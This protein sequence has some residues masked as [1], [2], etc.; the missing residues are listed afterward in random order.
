[1]R[2]V[3][4]PDRGAVIVETALALPIMFV[5]ILGLFDLGMWSMNANQAANAARDGARAGILTHE[6]AD[7]PSSADRDAI[8]AAALARLP[9]GT[10]RPDDVSISCVDQ[11][12]TTVPCHTA[13][14]DEDR[15][16]VEVRWVWPLVTPVAGMIGTTDGVARGVATMEIVGRPDPGPPDDGGT[17]P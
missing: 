16:R 17:E 4:T 15:I 3:R 7:A 8:V 13:R 12:D 9:E 6:Q 2:T 5:L 11:S 14:I 10:A 1:M